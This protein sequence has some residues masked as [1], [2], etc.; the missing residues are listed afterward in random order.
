S[1]LQLDMGVRVPLLANLPADKPVNGQHPYASFV[2]ELPKRKEDGTLALVPALLP[3][4]S[5]VAPDYLPLSRANLLQQS[6]KFLGERYG[7]G[8]SYDAR[9]CSGFVSDVYRSFGVELPRNTDDQA[10]TPAMTRI[11]LSKSDSHQ[12]RLRSE[13]RR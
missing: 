3:K 8:H 11:T 7:W 6:F 5:D 1:E 2:I 9:D 12:A 13:E 10:V 4:T